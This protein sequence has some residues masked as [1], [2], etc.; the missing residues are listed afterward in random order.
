VQS[1]TNLLNRSDSSVAVRAYN[2]VIADARD[3]SGTVYRDT[4]RRR[5]TRFIRNQDSP[6]AGDYVWRKARDLEG[7][8]WPWLARGARA[9]WEP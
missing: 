1:S 3:A 4:V 8:E 5:L 6:V 2:R 9:D 7:E